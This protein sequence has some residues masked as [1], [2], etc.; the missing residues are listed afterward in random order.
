MPVRSVARAAAAAL[1]ISVAAGCGG[2]GDLTGQQQRFLVKACMSLIERHVANDNTTITIDGHTL[3]LRDAEQ[4]YRVLRELRM[5]GVF[6]L[7][8]DTSLRYG[9]HSEL[10]DLCKDKASAPSP[11]TT[12]RPG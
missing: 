6:L 10:S 4:F 12:T 8:N 9:P 3:S 1:A 7:D 5:P 11:T 2:S